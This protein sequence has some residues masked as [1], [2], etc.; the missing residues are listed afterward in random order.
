[1]Q[2]E[3]EIINLK[4]F[5]NATREWVPVAFW[6]QGVVDCNGNKFEW[7]GGTEFPPVDKAHERHLQVVTA[8]TEPF[9]YYSG[10]KHSK[11][12]KIVSVK[13]KHK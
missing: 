4:L 8:A 9:V 7:P 3:Y 10:M 2:P 12:E 11:N 1:M 6:V 13:S 5:K